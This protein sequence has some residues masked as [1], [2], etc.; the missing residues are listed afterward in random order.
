MV[1]LKLLPPFPWCFWLRV[2]E[3]YR[4]KMLIIHQMPKVMKKVPGTTWPMKDPIGGYV[5]FLSKAVA[6]LKGKATQSISNT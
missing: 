6:Q 3:K 1:L 2:A 5:L 4:Q